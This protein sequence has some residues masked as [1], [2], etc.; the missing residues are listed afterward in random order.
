M[1]PSIRRRRGAAEF[2]DRPAIR[3]C[4]EMIRL[5]QAGR[6]FANFRTDRF[7]TTRVRKV[8]GEWS[9]LTPSG[10]SG[11]LPRITEEEMKG[12]LSSPVSGEVAR[13]AGGS[14]HGRP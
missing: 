4:V 10:P 6:C 11:H 1:S 14:E 8:D 12:S 9:A 5:V 2:M 13:R 7:G 3:A